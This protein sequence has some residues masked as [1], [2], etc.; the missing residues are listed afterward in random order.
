MPR[1]DS[2]NFMKIVLKIKLFLPKKK[3]KIFERWGLRSR[4]I[5]FG[6][7]RPCPQTPDTA[8]HCRFLAKRLIGPQ[9]EFNYSALLLKPHAIHQWGVLESFALS[10]TPPPPWLRYWGYCSTL[11][12]SVKLHYANHFL[13]DTLGS[14]KLSIERGQEH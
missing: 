9:R 5:A 4:P 3:Y 13:G 1:F 8:P 7:W 12:F 10:S 14:Q 2:I 6:G 11:S